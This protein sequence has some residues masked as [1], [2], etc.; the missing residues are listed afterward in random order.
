VILL[1]AE[2]GTAI[3]VIDH[4]AKMVWYRRE[5]GTLA[6]PRCLP[7]PGGKA[8]SPRSPPRIHSPWSRRLM[9]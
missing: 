1:A 6:S 2:I 9:N 4:V 8:F 7:E 5:I 3:L